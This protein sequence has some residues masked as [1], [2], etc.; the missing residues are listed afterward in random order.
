MELAAT[1]GASTR[2]HRAA[3]GVGAVV[4]MF[5]LAICVAVGDGSVSACPLAGKRSDN[6]GIAFHAARDGSVRFQRYY[7]PNATKADWDAIRMRV[8]D[9]VVL[10]NGPRLIRMGWSN[11]NTWDSNDESGGPHAQMFVGVSPGNSTTIASNLDLIRSIQGGVTGVSLSDTIAFAAAVAVSSSCWQTGVTCPAVGF[12]PGRADAVTISDAP[13]N[14]SYPSA[15]S[16][17][18]IEPDDLVT[19]FARLGNFTDAEIVALL[20]AHNMGNC[21]LPISGYAGPWTLT[22]LTL[23]NTFFQLLINNATYSPQNVTYNDTQKTQFIDDQGRMMLFA[24]MALT[25]SDDFLNSVK[26]YASNRAAFFSD[27]AS[28]FEKVLELGLAQKNLSDPVSTVAATINVV[29]V[30]ANATCYPK[31]SDPIFCATTVPDGNGNTVYTVHSTKTGWAALGVGVTSMAGGDVII[32]WLNSTGG[33]W[34]NTLSTVQH[35]ITVNSNS[36]WQQIALAETPPTWA[37]LSFSAVHQ[38]VILKDTEYIANNVNGDMTF[39]VSSYAPLSGEIDKPG[40]VSEFFQHDLS[41]VLA[42]G[43][44][45]TTTN[46]SF[47]VAAVAAGT[48]VAV[49]VVVA[50]ATAIAIITRRKRSSSPKKPVVVEASDTFVSTDSPPI[51]FIDS[52]SSSSANEPRRLLSLSSAGPLSSSTVTSDGQL[53][54]TVFVAATCSP[55]QP[56]M[57]DTHLNDDLVGLNSQT[58]RISSAVSTIVPDVP[59]DSGTQEKNRHSTPFAHISASAQSTR[60]RQLASWS[61]QICNNDNDAQYIQHIADIVAGRL[62]LHEREAANWDCA[63]VAAWVLLNGGLRHDAA[64]TAVVKDENITGQVLLLSSSSDLLGLFGFSAFGDRVLF[65]AALERLKH[66]VNNVPD[67][68]PAYD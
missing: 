25:R 52:G 58:S 15:F 3:A 27:F 24:D 11:A 47:P 50:V 51:A 53:S 41:G 49:A 23:D 17:A 1:F 32:G 18:S 2:K 67:M 10:G 28:A 38:N 62:P 12:R 14:P 36:A 8:V 30:S 68:P 37:K 59:S 35:A 6:T 9:Q 65:E 64:V 60:K 66:V 29:N 31:N 33:V 40:G 5:T 48:S 42:Y 45:S 54:H 22:P 44:E 16:P 20:G 7:V 39:A 21:H 55:H 43:N 4:A 56:S 13:H 61:Q 26:Y 63:D 57:P 19:S 46:G 34:T